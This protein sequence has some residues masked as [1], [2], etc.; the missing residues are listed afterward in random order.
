MQR[1]EFIRLFAGAAAMV[2][3]GEAKASKQYGPGVSDR[4]IKLGQTMA[5]SGP[6][7][8]LGAVG[9]TMIAYFQMINDK[10]GLRGRQIKLISLDDAYSPPKSVEQ[11]RRLVEQDE[12]FCIAC[13]LG[14][15]PNLAIRR[16]L[17]TNRVPTIF[18]VSGLAT[19]GD[20]A[21][22]PWRLA[23]TPSTFAETHHI[24]E[25][26]YSTRMTILDEITFAE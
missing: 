21:N 3:I 10:G 19:F 26:L 24:Q 15:A 23:Y 1:R 17:N 4:E 14:T 18:A 9:L 5:Y 16:Y 11:I 22:Y 7:S 13:P 25:L 2:P 6:A 12:V 8:A 20:R